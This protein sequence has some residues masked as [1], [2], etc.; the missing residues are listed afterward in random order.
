MET[1]TLHQKKINLQLLASG[2]RGVKLATSRT[3]T[4]KSLQGSLKSEA[5]FYNVCMLIRGS[6]CF[7]LGLEL[8]SLY[9]IKLMDC[10]VL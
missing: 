10:Y 3:S 5:G 7:E 1:L 8:C 6:H 4:T 2:Y 9:G